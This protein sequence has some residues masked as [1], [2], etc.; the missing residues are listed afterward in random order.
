MTSRSVLHKVRTHTAACRP[1][2][3][4]LATVLWF[5]KVHISSGR[6]MYSGIDLTVAQGTASLDCRFIE[7]K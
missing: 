3:C 6:L 5:A 7:Y 1:V 2:R 4:G